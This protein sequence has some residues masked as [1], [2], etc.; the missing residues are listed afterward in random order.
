M[1]T[2]GLTSK[3]RFILIRLSK[4]YERSMAAGGGGD[5]EGVGGGG[6][7]GQA[8]AVLS[9]V[10]FVSQGIDPAPRQALQ[11]PNI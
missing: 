3:T 11:G 9:G 5:G 6:S 10:Q 1:A 8:L 2:A 4:S 7:A